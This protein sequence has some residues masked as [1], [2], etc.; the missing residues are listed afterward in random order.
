[1]QVDYTTIMS[2]L[3]EIIRIVTPLALTLGLS[4]WVVRFVLSAMLGD[5]R[6]KWS[7]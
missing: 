2:Q 6:G 7:Y 4:Q 1:M 5:Y 3:A